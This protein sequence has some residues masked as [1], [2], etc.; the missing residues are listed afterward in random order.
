MVDL[1]GFYLDIIKDRLYTT[2]ADSRPRRSAQT[3][4]WHIAEAMV[5]WL[6]PILSFTAEEIWRQLPGAARGLGVPG[7]RWYPL[8]EAPGRRTPS[9][10][11]WP[12]LIALRTDVARELERLRVAGEIGAPLEAELDAVLH[13]RRS[14]RGSMRSATNC[15]S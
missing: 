4:M 13:R 2:P 12:A 7:A 9:A 6:A 14:T 5:R 15:D 3:A 8:P 10:I 11:D 1:G